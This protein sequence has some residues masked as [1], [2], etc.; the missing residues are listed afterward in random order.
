LRSFEQPC[1]IPLNR[2]RRVYTRLG[3]LDRGDRGVGVTL[4]PARAPAQD[5][6]GN[7]SD[8]AEHDGKEPERDDFERVLRRYLHETFADGSG[9]ELGHPLK[10][11][12]EA[13]GSPKVAG[14]HPKDTKAHAKGEVGGR[15]GQPNHQRRWRLPRE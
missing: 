15:S 1:G 5:K 13:D 7:Q 11:E 9:D 10:S 2:I 8:A 6:D 4:S 14:N 12:V 3:L